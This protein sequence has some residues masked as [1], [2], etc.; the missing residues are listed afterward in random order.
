[1]QYD[2]PQLVDYCINRMVDKL[3]VENAVRFFYYAHLHQLK[4]IKMYIADAMAKNLK[5]VCR[6]SGWQEFLKAD[7]DI[8]EEFFKLTLYASSLERNSGSDMDDD[9]RGSGPSRGRPSRAA[10]NFM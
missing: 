7:G 2:I 10:R 3:S 6:T 5:A 8:I 4:D 1:M 9:S